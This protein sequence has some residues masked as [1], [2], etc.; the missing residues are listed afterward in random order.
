MDCDGGS[1]FMHSS[2][3]REVMKSSVCVRACTRSRVV[4]GGRG[5]SVLF[6]DTQL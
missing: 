2:G 4:R 1:L 3:S 6:S 5:A